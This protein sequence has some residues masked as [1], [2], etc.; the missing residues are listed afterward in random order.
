MVHL[1]MALDTSEVFPAVIAWEEFSCYPTACPGEE[2]PPCCPALCYPPL[3]LLAEAVEST[4]SLRVS[5]AVVVFSSLPVE[6]SDFLPVDMPGRPPRGYCRNRPHKN[7]FGFREQAVSSSLLGVDPVLATV[8]FG[9]TKLGAS[10]NSM[11]TNSRNV[12][13]NTV[14]IAEHINR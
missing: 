14:A 2:A 3:H 11:N 6:G 10:P 5:P 4:T 9:I 7:R 8:V 1:L 13:H 12:W